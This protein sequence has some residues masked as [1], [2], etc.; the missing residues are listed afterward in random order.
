MNL[1]IEEAAGTNPIWEKLTV[2][3]TIQFRLLIMGL[4][5]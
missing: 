1:K 4:P 3:I 5:K 2:V